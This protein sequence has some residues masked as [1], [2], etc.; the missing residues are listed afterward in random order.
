MLW[1]CLEV[2][3]DYTEVMVG[4]KFQQVLPILVDSTT[5]KHPR[6]AAMTG[7]HSSTPLSEEGI[8][9]L[10][11]NVW[12]ISF[13]MAISTYSLRGSLLMTAVFLALPIFWKSSVL[14]SLY[15]HSNNPV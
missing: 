12:H 6:S 13:R 2:G 9:S 10:P 14:L 3:F 1:L 15:G 4:T 11:E 5:P 7:T 8:V